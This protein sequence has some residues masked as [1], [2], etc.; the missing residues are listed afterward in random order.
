MN[1]RPCLFLCWSFVL[2]PTLPAASVPQPNALS[3]QEQ[4]AGW[5]SLFDGSTLN[6]WTPRGAARWDA[7]D[8]TIS[9]RLGTGGGYLFTDREFT[10]FELRIE[11]WVDE[12]VNSGVFLRCPP[13]EANP[14]NKS[15]EVNIFDAHA[16]WP[17]GS[18]NDLG[19]AARQPPTVGRWNTYEITAQGDH[20][21]IRLNGVVA[22]DVRD[23]K[24]KRG[25]I[26]LQQNRPGG[27]LRFRSIRV[28]VLPAG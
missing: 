15:Y 1:L 28:R 18:I 8:G 16:S 11:F 24:F 22:L 12:K 25:T 9:Y 26:G 27:V 6:G 23:E 2:L 21:V 17:T 5:I 10:D 13:G 20:L 19:R 7:V 14:A 4:A 3:Q